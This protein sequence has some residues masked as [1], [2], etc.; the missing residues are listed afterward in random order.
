MSN[1]VTNKVQAPKHVIQAMLNTDGDVDF[2]MVAP[3]CGPCGKDWDGISLDAEEAAQII[4]GVPFDDNPLIA[5]LQ[6]SNRDRFDITKLSAN[7]FEQFVGMVRNWRACGYLHSM[8]F[9]RKV[10]GTKWNACSSKAYPDEGCCKFDTAWSCPTSVLLK[11]SERFPDDTIN[12][13]Y[14]DEDIGSNCGT[15]TLKDGKFVNQDIASKWCD[16]NDGAKA[17]WRAFA[18]QVKG[19]E[20]DIEEEA[21]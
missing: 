1:W 10:W 8:D 2:E 11:L 9:A 5:A 19:W 16:L 20:P 15:F 4:C 13:V 7:S 12:V 6:S 3:F 21:A 18:L 14:A 17:K